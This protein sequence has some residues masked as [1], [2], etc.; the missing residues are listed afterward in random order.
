MAR[1]CCLS[2][3][4][5]LALLT[6]ACVSGSAVATAEP[7]DPSRFQVVATISERASSDDGRFMVQAELRHAPEA[8]TADQRFSLKAVNVPAAGCDPLGSDLFNDGFE[9]P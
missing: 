7:A 3:P 5:P 6:L 4:L 9:N 8:K 2:A 1:H